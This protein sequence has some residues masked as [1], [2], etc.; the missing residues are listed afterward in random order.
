MPIQ[1][2]ATFEAA[3]TDFYAT[4]QAN[5]AIIQDPDIN[6]AS[7]PDF[8]FMQFEY[9]N[10]SKTKYVNAFTNSLGEI[11]ALQEAGIAH[12][13]PAYLQ[14]AHSFLGSVMGGE[15]DAIGA[16]AELL[17]QINAYGNLYNAGTWTNILT[18][19]NRRAMGQYTASFIGWLQHGASNNH[20]ALDLNL[21]VASVKG[22][23]SQ[24]NSLK[25]GVY[26]TVS[27]LQDAVLD[28]LDP[29]G[30]LAP[31]IIHGPSGNTLDSPNQT[32]LDAGLKDGDQIRVEL[33]VSPI[34]AGPGPIFGG[35]GFQPVQ[36]PN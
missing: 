36:P 2:Q 28:F 4:V 15:Y 16:Q 30:A 25:A 35:G 8:N 27:I 23:Q 34:H 11:D 26:W 3:S 12:Y 32:L 10:E 7:I 5:L 21:T 1:F 29:R 19:L 14:G 33:G 6:L 9:Y 24:S 20:Q 31:V 13:N 17:Q 22:G 18:W